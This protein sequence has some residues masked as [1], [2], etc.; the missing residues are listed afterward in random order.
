MSM[1]GAGVRPGDEVLCPAF[2]YWSSA[3]GI[4]Q[5]GG[6]PV[7][8]DIDPKTY[9]ID[10]VL[11]E[12]QITENT[13]AILAVHIHG[14]VADMDPINEIA[15]KHGLWVVEDA[16]QAHGATYK[17]RKA[18]SL[19]N[20]AGFSC[21]RSKCLSGGE[22][23]ILTTNDA[24]IAEVA[25]RC[26]QIN[27]IDQPNREG[28]NVYALGWGYRPHELVNAFIC[29]QMDRFDENLAR[30]REFA[31]FLSEQLADIPGFDGPYTPDYAESCFFTYVVSF[32]PRQLGLDVSAAEWRKAAGKALAAEGIGLGNWQYEPMPAM[33]VFAD[34]V[35][36]G[37]GFPWSF[38][39]ARQDIVYRGEDYPRTIEFIATHGYLGGVFPPNE[40]D[41][42]ERY[43]E[44]FQKVSENAHRALELAEE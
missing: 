23:G 5:Q 28:F 9:T 12:E 21:N 38:P 15:A 40:M 16:C 34:K 3:A 18:G 22:G 32:D 20:V 41:L 13:T 7:F 37:K 29:S 26:R 17:G 42:I 44:G 39:G 8:V 43:V 14:L 6:I 27:A 2:T 10:P 24:D 36:F 11:I 33:N 1:M 4:L 35:G 19:G 30:R 25:N 31:A